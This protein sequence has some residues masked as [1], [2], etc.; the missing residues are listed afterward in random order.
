MQLGKW[1]GLLA[2]GV[3]IY[4]LWEIRQVLLL[5]FAAVVI[6][7]VLNRVVRVLRRLR[8]KRGLAIAITI[9]LLLLIVFGLFAII[10]PRFLDQLQNLSG[11]L[12]AALERLSTIY[13]WFQGR[14]P[15]IVLGENQGINRL[16]NETQALVYSTFGNFFTILN[17]S[18][19]AVVNLLLVVAATVMLLVNPGSY[20]RTVISAFPAFYRD[21]VNEILNKCEHS[22]VGWFQGTLVG[23]VTIGTLSYI[24]LLIL[25]VPLPLVNAIL[26]GLLE[27]IP[28]V[29]P[30]I[31][32]V[33]AI[34][35]A[36]LDAPWKGLAVLILYFFIQQFE[37]LAL[38]PILMKRTVA[39]MPLFTLLSVVIFAALFGLLGLF[40]AVPLLIV[41]QTWLQEVLV[42]DV[43]D[44][45]EAPITTSRGRLHQR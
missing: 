40:L 20:R 42:K 30:V 15:G 28:N 35:L 32:A 21:R 34:L 45:W 1:V 6:A 39:L 41:V 29:G 12:P 5:L 38:M 9:A 27:I 17:S 8:I 4:L 11:L 13:D 3:S 18:L 16:L 26:A 14:I 7:T 43:M 10:L 19:N 2:L 23:M 25:G 22:L 24:G 44:S 36:L 31:S 33:P 37:S